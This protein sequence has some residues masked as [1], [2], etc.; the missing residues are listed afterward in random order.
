MFGEDSLI[1]KPHQKDNFE[2]DLKF[3]INGKSFEYK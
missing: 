1:I 2:L 3:Q